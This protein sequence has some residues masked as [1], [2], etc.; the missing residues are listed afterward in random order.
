MPRP[1]HLMEEVLAAYRDRDWHEC[2]RRVRPLV[3]GAP[4]AD[5]PRQLLASLYL[6]LGNRRLAL[7][8]YRRLLATAVE[9]GQLLRAIAF[10]RRVDQL[11]AGAAGPRRWTELQTRLRTHGLPYLNLVPIGSARPWTEGQML[12]LPRE[13]FER[14]ALGPTL[15][16]MGLAP[17]AVDTS[18][19]TLW[20]VI[21]GRTRW[22][23]ALSDGR[24]GSESI[25]AE[26]DAIRLDPDL[27]HRA[28]IS[29]VPELPTECMRFDAELV[30]EL[31]DVMRARRPAVAA[32]GLTTETRALLPTRPLRHD[33]L[34]RA[35]DP[36]H[37][38]SE[39][40]RRLPAG[41]PAPA[42]LP[43]A[44]ASEWLEH[45]M[46]SLDSPPGGTTTPGSTGAP[47]PPPRER[48]VDLPAG[49][50]RP[51][52]RGRPLVA[53]PGPVELDHGLVIPPTPDP[54]AAPIPDL[55]KPV[56][57]R[58]GSRVGVSFASRLAMLRLAATRLAPAGG[59]LI[60]LSTAG[61]GVRF[62]SAD[63]GARRGALAGAVVAIDLDLPDGQPPLRV[64]G[65][66][67]WIEADDPGE[68]RFGI[69]FVLLTEP[70]R[71]RIAGA[72]AAVPSG[73]PDFPLES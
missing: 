27:A 32:D 1:R 53:P 71:R 38:T 63:L 42:A 66:V 57:R 68:V 3:D 15:I 6:Q 64:A 33:D 31:R 41:P 19:D 39:G 17:G 23:L 73:R 45:G 61:L 36:V 47:A 13:W 37:D 46:L 54:F 20:E 9:R 62:A 5:G 55:G 29:F 67:R 28:T 12:A 30:A 44:D 26:G 51:P 49:D 65:Q 70:D 10:Q 43:G 16:V 11:D 14:A 52:R 18:A 58:R 24:A 59:T 48:T 60:D 25:A 4:L 2:V 50:S 34:D 56:E 8:Q 40:P 7:P 21:A 72:L 35:P 22:S 69:E